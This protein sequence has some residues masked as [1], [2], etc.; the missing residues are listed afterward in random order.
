M[1]SEPEP[2]KSTIPTPPPE[3][4]SV[5]E[6][7]AS[8]TQRRAAEGYV[9][10]GPHKPRFTIGRSL[11]E[12]ELVAD[13]ERERQRQLDEFNAKCRAAWATFITERGERYARCMVNNFD[14]RS[15][16]QAA[17]VAKL[18]RYCQGIEEYIRGGQGVVLYGPR[19]TGKDH[20]A[21][22]V[23]RAAIAKG[24]S[25]R[26]RNGMDLFGDVRDGFDNGGRESD[27]I[28]RLCY[29]DVLYLSDPLPP[30]GA[31][32]QFQASLLFRVL[33]ARYSRR[34]P[35]VCTLNVK[36]GQ[37]LNERIGSQNADRIRDGALA[38]HCNWDSYRKVQEI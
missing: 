18:V 9:D 25:V 35:L 31:L 26:W 7:A 30:F 14:A 12:A 34:K 8:I 3:N 15:P 19:G 2:V 29:P 38:L 23:C 17:V 11:T 13:E 22:A 21:T 20:L 37:E 16:E 27:V 28:K 4:C 6:I 33:D 10:H 5:E 1:A 32:S 24:L 36:D